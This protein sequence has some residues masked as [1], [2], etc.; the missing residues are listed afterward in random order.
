MARGDGAYVHYGYDAARSIVVDMLLDSDDLLPDAPA[1][2]RIGEVQ[3]VMDAGEVPESYWSSAWD[4]LWEYVQGDLGELM[5]R[6]RQKSGHPGDYWLAGVDNFGWRHQSGE[7]DAFFATRADEILQRVL[8]NTEN[9]FYIYD[10]GDHI[11]IDNAH[12]DAPMG[13]EI[14]TI[15]P[16]SEYSVWE[17][18]PEGETNGYGEPERLWAEGVWGSSALDAAERCLGEDSHHEPR[19]RRLEAGPGDTATGEGYGGYPEE[20]WFRIRVERS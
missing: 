1:D 15:L 13:G 20:G 8:P 4:D 19:F 11:T 18:F 6:V 5:A 17:V 7:S 10:Q 14:Y 2:E 3:R 12:H 9:D 16:V